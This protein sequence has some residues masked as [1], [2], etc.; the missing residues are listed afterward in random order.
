MNHDQHA[1]RDQEGG[2]RGQQV[3]FGALCRDTSSLGA[4]ARLAV[5]VQY[6]DRWCSAAAGRSFEHL[7]DRRC[8]RGERQSL[9]PETL[10]PRF[11][12]QR[13]IRARRAARA[14]RCVGIVEARES[15]CRSGSSNV[16]GPSAGKVEPPSAARDRARATPAHTPAAFACPGVPIC[17]STE[18]S[19]N[20]T[21]EWITLCGWITMSMRSAAMPNSQL[22]SMTSSPLFISVAESTEILRPITHFG[23]AHA[24]SGVT[25]SRSSRF[26]NGPPGR[27]QHQAAHR[28]C[29]DSPTPDRHW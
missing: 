3:S 22:A 21:I 18:P 11:R 16:S 17:A 7:F 28:R 27:R 8:D 2:D 19:A 13:S 9:C 12:W 10:R 29:S 26:R 15:G 6:V 4:L 24:S 5:D 14:Q 1:E 25:P 20:S 23:C